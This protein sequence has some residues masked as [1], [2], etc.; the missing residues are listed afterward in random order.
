MQKSAKENFIN[1]ILLL[2]NLNLTL[3]DQALDTMGVPTI[4]GKDIQPV[5][6][7]TKNDGFLG[8]NMIK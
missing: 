1:S 7:P 8:N 2:H 3:N 4:T 5:K 6:E